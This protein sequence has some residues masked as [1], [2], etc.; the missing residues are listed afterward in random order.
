MTIAGLDSIR[1][2]AGD[3]F[4]AMT[5]VSYVAAFSDFPVKAFAVSMG[6]R[7]TS[8]DIRAG[9]RLILPSPV[10]ARK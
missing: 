2:Q 10:P 1:I 7:R 5:F 3:L 4:C 8:G 6:R 9:E